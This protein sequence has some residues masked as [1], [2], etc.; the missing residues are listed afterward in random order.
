LYPTFANQIILVAGTDQQGARYEADFWTGATAIAAP[1]EEI[2][3][4]ARVADFFAGTRVV[5][6]TSYAA[7][8]VAGVA[9]QLLGMDP[10]LT[11][12]QV[13]DYIV[14]GAKE[15]RLD[16]AT[17]QLELPDSVLGAPEP[18]YQLDAYGALTLLSRER[19]GTP[20]CGFPVYT[21][22]GQ[23]LYERVPG[24][25]VAQPVTGAQE[26]GRVTVARGGRI[27]AAGQAGGFADW[28]EFDHLGQSVTPLPDVFQRTYLEK[29][30]A[31]VLFPVEPD[32]F[33]R[34]VRIRGESGSPTTIDLWS[35]L[36]PTAIFFLAIEVQPSPWG[37]WLAVNSLASL[38]PTPPVAPSVFEWS[39]VPVGGGPPDS[40]L[41]LVFE[42][43]IEG[44]EG[45]G[46]RGPW[47][48]ALAAQTSCG[49]DCYLP[50]ADP[51]SMAWSPDNARLQFAFPK[52]TITP[53]SVTVSR[54][55]MRT[56]TFPG[57][58]PS[59][60]RTDLTPAVEGRELM[61]PRFTAN[62][63][64]VLNE[65]DLATGDCHRAW[66]NPQTG[67]LLADT[68]TAAAD[69]DRIQ[70]PRRPFNGPP[71]VRAARRGPAVAAMLD[72]WRRA[73]PEVRRDGTRR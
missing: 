40:V 45:P 22:N 46:G 48:A 51:G 26:L 43:Q 47:V 15:P 27:L 71:V 50:L 17:G 11:A 66:R 7:P 54:S 64:L 70:D 3:T 59:G 69:C 16:P 72:W 42:A 33:I 73:R 68:V 63:E 24:V 39:L 9:A 1:A 23:L 28:I 13:K 25:P 55:V 14:R 10:S 35:L 30:T 49:P 56:V 6:G 8:F 4:L 21:R 29:D 37:D 53:Q 36:E 41:R 44:P 60:H 20:I 38:P 12:A 31:D 52:G 58:M 2:M 65:L 18:V 67:Q 19:P 62:G 5:N 32:P 61:W 34:Q 57:G